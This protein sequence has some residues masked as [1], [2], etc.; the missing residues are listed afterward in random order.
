MSSSSLDSM[1]ENY[2]ERGNG[3]GNTVSSERTDSDL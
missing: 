2:E 3:E 1:C